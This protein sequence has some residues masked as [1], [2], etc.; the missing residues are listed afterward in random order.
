MGIAYDKQKEYDKAIEAYQK[1][2]EI[3]P[4]D[5]TTY[6]NMGIA[7]GNQEEYDKAI[8]TYQKA[9]EINPKRKSAY[10]NLFELQLMHNQTFT[11]EMR[12]RELFHNDKNEFIIYE[13]L[14]ILQAIAMQS[15]YELSLETWGQKYEGLKY[16]WG[17][18]EIDSWLNRM[19]E[20]ELKIRLLEAVAFFKAKLSS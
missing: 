17:W 12:F 1:A 20:G 11:D 18:N 13:M 10:T 9:L 3:N 8:E 2:L 4:N 5:D 19:E 16:K 6:Y 15:T 7:Y 14:K